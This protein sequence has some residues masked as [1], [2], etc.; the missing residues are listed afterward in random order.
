MTRARD[1]GPS[2]GAP[3]RAWV[4][5]HARLLV[6][7]V[8]VLALLAGC[9]REVVWPEGAPTGARVIECP[10]ADCGPLFRAVEV[11]MER[12]MPGHAAIDG[13]RLA[14]TVCGSADEPQECTGANGGIGWAGGYTVVVDVAGTAAPVLMRVLCWDGPYY[15]GTVE[16]SGLWCSSQPW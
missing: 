3:M 7:P 13:M 1:L 14:V 2:S 4:D 12:R 15:T 11:A 8:L 5:G 10:A 6:L 16:W 9:S